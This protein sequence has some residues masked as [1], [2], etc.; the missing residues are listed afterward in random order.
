[1]SY[2]NKRVI[3]EKI[4]KF[5]NLFFSIM[6]FISISLIYWADKILYQMEYIFLVIVELSCKKVQFSVQ[7]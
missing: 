7:V 1:M 2:L 4:I 5:Y 3:F 6:C